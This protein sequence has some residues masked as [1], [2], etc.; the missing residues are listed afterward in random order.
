VNTPNAGT[1][2][3]CKNSPL[4]APDRRLMAAATLT[5]ERRD[6]E[7]AAWRLWTAQRTSPQP[8]CITIK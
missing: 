8:L 4:T 5:A 2:L 6:E 7:A 1:F 3:P